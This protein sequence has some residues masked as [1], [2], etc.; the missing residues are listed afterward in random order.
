MA[1]LPAVLRDRELPASVR[2]SLAAARARVALAGRFGRRVTAPI[3]GLGWWVLVIGVGSW[4]IA[5]VLRWTEFAYLAT[6]A[7]M[8]FGLCA[9]M[10]LGRSIFAITLTVEPSRIAVGGSS[11]GRVVVRNIAAR[12][13]LPVD[14]ELPV[15]ASGT[16]FSLPSLAP[17]A[18]FDD[19]FVVPTNRRSV[20]P[21]GPAITVRGDPV[22]LIRR[23]VRWT[24]QIELFVHPLT[25]P[26]D[27]TG[28][29]LLRDL[30]GQTTNEVSM[31]DLAFHALRD[32]Q[33]GDDRRSIHWRS[34]ARAGKFVVRQFLDTRRSHLTAVV[35]SRRDSYL[36][37]EHFEIAISAA[38]SLVV[39]SV[40]DGQETT[41]VAGDQAVAAGGGRQLLDA[42]TRADFAET[43]IADMT[44]RA[45]RIAPGTS[46]A[47][48][49]TGPRTS[50][51][52]L[53][54][55][56]TYLPFEARR[57]G[58]VVDPTK[59]MGLADT[60]NMVVMTLPS[61]RDLPAL[62]KGRRL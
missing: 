25:V 60:G 41:V 10:G 46:V 54:L 45:A 29:G 5:V 42:L 43:P 22:G 35:D 56:A 40:T 31:S 16:G 50:F 39:R 21:I 24:N 8:L 26:L 58:V 28:P 62:I 1:L 20:V 51:T 30:E 9:L 59:R 53:Q 27:S 48:L 23:E 17:E 18:E 15:G 13:S 38:A 36:D 52:Q 37:P 12:R 2:G 44:A 47:F 49:I 7:L 6:A 61:L 3:T 14:L 4:T 55:A 33:P 11:V 34:S 32:Y 57:V 19:I